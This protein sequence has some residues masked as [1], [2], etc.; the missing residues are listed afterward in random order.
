MAR[1]RGMMTALQAA[2]AGVAG[3]IEG[4]VQQQTAEE[5][6][7]RVAAALA[8]QQQQ[9]EESRQVRLGELMSQ[10]FEPVADVR[11]KQQDAVGAA[12]SL[13]G[14]A[15][16]AASG[17][18]ALPMPSES[19]Q[20]SLAGGYAGAQ[21]SRTINFGGREL[22]L[23]ET[24]SERQ[25]RL[26]RV[27]ASMS[28]AE[29][30]QEKLERSAEAQRMA[31]EKKAARDSQIQTYMDVGYSRKD[32]T[33]L[34]DNST[35]MTAMRGQDISAANARRG[36]QLARERFE[37]DKGA[38]P[39][40]AKGVPDR[41]SGDYTDA[42]NKIA[43]FLPTTDP[44]T[45]T[46]VPPKRPLSGTKTFLVQ[47]GSPER[48]FAGRLALLGASKMGVKTSEE[49]LYNTLAKEVATAYAMKE[50]QGR[51]VSNAD[52]INRVSQISM[53]PNE[54]GNL[55]IQKVKGDRLRTW[56]KTLQSGAEIPQIEPGQTAF[57]PKLTA[58][59]PMSGAEWMQQNPKRDDE[60]K[61]QYRARYNQRG[62]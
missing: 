25:E 30:E 9:D 41:F 24:Q 13:I 38:K 57:V 34:T 12:G 46:L 42:L 50:Q 5:E 51:N 16:N 27:A 47:E 6:R 44:K 40:A 45:G 15:L 20:A 54:V 53:Q 35:A 59:A 28:R 29:K 17:N 11:R 26:S 21:P 19:A 8:R 31:S 43:D 56:A 14:S 22:S 61:E 4:R 1:R 62:G 55:E 7:S 36:E 48:G 33:M 37:F 39:S 49:Q 18:A 52:L 23:R 58:D 60:T 10:G 32:A 2:L 3:G